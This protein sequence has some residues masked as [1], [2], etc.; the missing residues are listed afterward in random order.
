MPIRW[1]QGFYCNIIH[2]HIM[3]IDHIKLFPNSH[4]K[5]NSLL[6]AIESYITDIKVDFG[7]FKCAVI[8]TIRGNFSEG[9]NYEL[10]SG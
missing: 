7:V 6:N 8:Q 5:L 9:N 2:I 4:N 10:T 1:I 3:Y